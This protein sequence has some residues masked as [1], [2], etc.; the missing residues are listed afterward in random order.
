MEILTIESEA[1]RHN[2]VGDP[3]QRAISVLLPKDYGQNNRRY[4]VVYLLTMKKWNWT[5]G[6]IQAIEGEAGTA[7][8]DLIWVIV[9]GDNR[10]GF[11]RFRRSPVLGDY[12]E[13]LTEEVVPLVDA[14]YRTLPRP[15]SRGIGGVSDC[16]E[17]ALYVAMEH[18]DVFGVLVAQGLSGTFAGT[19]PWFE[20]AAALNPSS[21]AD[22]DALGFVDQWIFAW[23]AVVAPNPSRPSLFVDSPGQ[24]NGDQV[25]IN[26]F[27]WERFLYHDNTR[28]LARYVAQANRLR[29]IMIVAGAADQA[30]PV[31]NVRRLSSALTKAKIAHEYIE[32][33]GGHVWLDAEMLAF[34]AQELVREGG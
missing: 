18:A 9:E 11:P 25:E 21:L 30:N 17:D 16:G 33:E 28:T 32:H 15:E 23:M 22:Y 31:E 7:L 4:S 1:L 12:E 10:L 2:L 3:P 14:Q 26:P 5:P 20:K 34:F 6:I 29:S 13:Y 24:A 27:I 19:R 8:G